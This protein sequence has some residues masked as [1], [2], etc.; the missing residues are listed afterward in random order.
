MSRPSRSSLAG[1][2]LGVAVTVAGPLMVAAPV[3]AAISPD[4]VDIRPPAERSQPSVTPTLRAA[5]QR[6]LDRLRLREEM[7]GVSVAILFPDGT[8]WLGTSGMAV[9]K[10]KRPVSPDT[11]FALASVTKTFTAALILSLRDE[12]KL[13]LEQSVVTYLPELPID[14]R[15]TVRQLLD[16]TSGLRDFFFD[17]QI[18]KALL[19]DR[20]RTWDADRSLRYVGKSYFKPGKGW[21]YSNTNYL[22]LG[23]LAERLGKAS[24]EDQLRARFFEP[25]GLSHTFDQVDGKPGGPVAHGYRFSKTSARPIDLTDGSDIAPFTSVVTAAGAAGSLASTPSDLVHW[26]RAL[27]SGV[28]LEPESLRAMFDDVARTAKKDPLVPYGLGVQAVELDGHPAYGHSGRLL[29]FRALVR[30]LPQERIAIAVLSNQSRT[31]PA[32][33]AR[34]LLRIALTPT[35]GCADCREPR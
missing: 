30:W 33:V 23:V 13:S 21:H 27:Y 3:A 18:D 6:R 35:G 24:L 7:P 25:L 31:D 9:I 28:V 32:I 12:R 16:H 17:P 15:I 4:L 11:A 2:I 20:G 34:S 19:S 29:G 26:V 1:V 14:H 8:M 10:D 22:I 5:L